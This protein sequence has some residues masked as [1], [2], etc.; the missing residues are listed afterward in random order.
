[1]TASCPPSESTSRFAI[2]KWMERPSSSKF[3]TLLVR[4]VSRPSP[5]ATTR[6]PTESSSPMTSLTAN[7]SL[8][9]KTGWLRLRSTLAT[10][11][12][13]F[14][15]EISAI[16]RVS[17]KWPSRRAKNLQT[18]TLFVSS[19]PQPRTLRTSNRRLRW[20]HARSRTES[21]WHNP[22]RALRQALPP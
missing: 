4:N 15:S 1:M 6:A 2:M 10:T 17:A 19:K 11:F 21:Q 8:Q 13:A 12:H 20:W 18:T 9:F 22:K 7:H 14:W 5:Q 3:G 16:L